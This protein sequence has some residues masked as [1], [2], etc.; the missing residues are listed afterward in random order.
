M[1]YSQCPSAPEGGD[2]GYFPRKGAVEE[3][4]AAAAFA[5]KK[6][7]VS[8]VVQTSYGLHLIRVT[9]RKSGPPSDFS[10][11]VDQVRELAGENMM[12]DILSKERLAARIE[13][14]LGEAP[15]ASKPANARRS[16]FG[17]P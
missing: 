6:D 7:E 8:A 17:N 4:F 1:T 3:P 2:I 5:L 15:A 11:I 16:L 9:D 12:L 13:I 14:K 10:K